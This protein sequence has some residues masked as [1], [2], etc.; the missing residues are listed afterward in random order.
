MTI[1]DYI[2]QTKNKEQYIKM[3]NV[4]ADDNRF[5]LFSKRDKCKLTKKM[6]RMIGLKRENITVCSQK[7]FSSIKKFN[8]R[9]QIVMVSNKSWCEDLLRHIRNSFFHNHTKIYT[10]NG[11]RYFLFCD[12]YNGKDSSHI[13]LT[14]ENFI[15]IMNS[16][17]Q[18]I[19]EIKSGK[20]YFNKNYRKKSAA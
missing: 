11:Q 19:S 13:C 18:A 6:K 20:T 16:Y 14:E 5:S 7:N 4:F 1:F 2:I 12:L 9:N 8:K 15:Y 17:E 3:L 10:H